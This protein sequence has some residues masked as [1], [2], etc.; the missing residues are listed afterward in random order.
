VWRSE[1]T[2]L[3]TGGTGN[4]VRDCMSGANRGECIGT[5]R[6]SMAKLRCVDQVGSRSDIQSCTAY[7]SS[8]GGKALVLASRIRVPVAGPCCDAV[9]GRWPLGSRRLPGRALNLAD[10]H[11][12]LARSGYSCRPDLHTDS[13]RQHKC[14]PGSNERLTRADWPARS[15]VPPHRRAARAAASD[16]GCAA[17]RV[18]PATRCGRSL[19]SDP[20]AGC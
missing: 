8:L 1:M 11:W 5:P 9:V 15:D 14:L 6:C 17:S 13:P 16:T 19:S 10:S 18:G 7:A 2:S 3:R 20:A 12:L 4:A